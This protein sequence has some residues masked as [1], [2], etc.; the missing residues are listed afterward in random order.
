MSR[1]PIKTVKNTAGKIKTADKNSEKMADKRSEKLANKNSKVSSIKQYM[2]NLCTKY[3]E[4]RSST[5]T[6]LIPTLYHK[7]ELEHH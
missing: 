2:V 3:I 4:G 5:K 1:R 6:F 7:F